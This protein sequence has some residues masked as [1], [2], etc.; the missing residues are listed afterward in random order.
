MVLIL[1]EVI[2]ADGNA[3]WYSSYDGKYTVTKG[4]PISKHTDSVE[5]YEHEIRFQHLL[6]K[7]GF[8]PR[9]IAFNIE[10]RWKNRNYLLWV[11]EDAGLPIE[12]PDI[13]SANK[14]LDSLYDIGIVLT[15][16]TFHPDMFLKGFDGK[17]RVVDFKHTVQH[18]VPIS[19]SERRY[20]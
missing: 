16:Y 2:R 19:E 20:I 3:V 10:K 12:V 14:L 18:P 13:P 5:V 8:A 15:P 17:I 11:S 6:S 1:G 9:L 4:M 7:R